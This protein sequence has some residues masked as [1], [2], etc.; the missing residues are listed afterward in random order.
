MNLRDTACV[1]DKLTEMIISPTRHR[2][3][4]GLPRRHAM[5]ADVESSSVF[6]VDIHLKRY[7]LGDLYV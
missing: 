7:R 2:R 1:R 6:N 5:L 3:L 4:T